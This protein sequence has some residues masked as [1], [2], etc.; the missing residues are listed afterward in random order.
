MSSIISKDN[1][2]A[3]EQKRTTKRI[4]HLAQEIGMPLNQEGNGIKWVCKK[5]FN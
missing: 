4:R 3:P 5:Y 1:I 2:L